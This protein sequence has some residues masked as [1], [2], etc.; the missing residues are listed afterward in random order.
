MS[1]SDDDIKADLL[2]EVGE[3]VERL[4]PQIIAP[5][6]DPHDGEPLNAVFRAFHTIEEGGVHG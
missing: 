1:A 6:R 3:R 5:E 2:A 4:A